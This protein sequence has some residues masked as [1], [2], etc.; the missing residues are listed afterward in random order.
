[1]PVHGVSMGY[2]FNERSAADRH[3]TQYF[4]I[5]G[6]RGIYHEGWTAVTKHATPWIAMGELPAFADDVWELYSPDD[7][8]QSRDLSEAMPD[9]LRELQELFLEEARRYSVLPLDDRRVERFNPAI[10]GRPTLIHGN[11]QL[12]YAGMGRLT[13][14]TVLNLKNVS[15]AVA[16]DIEVQA[17]GAGG[18]IVAQGGAFGGWSLYLR[19]DA[20]PVYCYNL[21]GMQQT[22]VA[23]GSPLEPGRHRLVMTFDYDG[24]G[25]GMGGTVRLTVDGD[26]VGEGRLERTI[27]LVFSL[28]ETLDV[29]RDSGSAVSDDYT[30]ETS[31]FTGV[32]HQVRLEIAEGAPNF[33]HL[34]DPLQRLAVALARQ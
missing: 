18:V 5:G 17:D 13:E 14:A 34:I 33:S 2:S 22:K 25:P 7:W 21:L 26:V 8:T 16:A 6:N 15:H 30:A 23:A 1:M 29:G 27:P 28:D 10:A 31:E 9:K 12:L 11:S 20:T 32:I 24:G 3:R 19:P 4:E